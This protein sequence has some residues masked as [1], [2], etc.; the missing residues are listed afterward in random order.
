MATKQIKV[1]ISSGNTVIELEGDTTTVLAEF[2]SLKKNGVGKLSKISTGTAP[3]TSAEGTGQEQ[4]LPAQTKKLPP[5]HDIVLKALPKSEP[6]WILIYSCFASKEGAVVFSR[7]DLLSLYKSSK[8]MTENRRANL[9]NNLKQAVTKGWLSNIANDQYS[10]L[11]DGKI[12]AQEIVTRERAS[13]R[14]S[15][16]KRSPNTKK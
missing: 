1:K 10:L 9:S 14:K 7:K 15:A 11:P 16:K 4:L 5:L 12:K 3:A 6:E 13:K 8:R 2:K